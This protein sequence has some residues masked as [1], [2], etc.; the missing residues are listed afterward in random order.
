MEIP[1]LISRFPV[2][3]HAHM[4]E[5][6]TD[7]K[8]F[9]QT[10][11]FH[12]LNRNTAQYGDYMAAGALYCIYIYPLGDTQKL[13]AISRYFAYWALID[14]LYFDNSIDLDHI[15]QISDRYTA[16]LEGIPNGDKLFAPVTEFCARTDWQEDAKN[17]FRNEVKRY[18]NAVI[19]LRITEAHK[20]VISVQEYLSYR[21][22]NV[23]MWVIFS[24]LYDT[25]DDLEMSM[26]YSPEFAEIF[27]YSSMCIGILLD[28]Y[29]L[30]AH[31]AEISDYTNLVYVV[32]R[33]DHC[34]EEEAINKSIR[35]FYDYEA[36]MEEACNRLAATC[37]R[38]VLYFKYVQSGSV[39]YC[40]ES[41]KMRYLQKSDIDE[42]QANGRTI[43]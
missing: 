12:I 32:R 39:R 30:N 4:E 9:F 40:N 23:A 18:L 16:A 35:L 24:L 33:A 36:R 42:D 11:A 22:F 19:Q 13:K 17:L 34:S 7:I 14:D 25:Q 26:F 28:L 37:P 5:I 1:L 43:L 27:E 15:Q 20:K 3:T 31:K 29:N 38:A 10:D 2:M 21:H 8:N 6:T 41:R